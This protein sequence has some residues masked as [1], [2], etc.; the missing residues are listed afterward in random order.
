MISFSEEEE[1]EEERTRK[2]V[3]LCFFSSFCGKRKKSVFVIIKKETVWSQS[4]ALWI[5]TNF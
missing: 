3:A 2:G 5:E 1:E 4:V